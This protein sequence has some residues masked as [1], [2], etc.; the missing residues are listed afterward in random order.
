VD[1][2][3]IT[4]TTTLKRFN[5]WKIF[6]VGTLILSH[7]NTDIILTFIIVLHLYYTVTLVLLLF[8]QKIHLYR[9][10]ICMLLCK[11]VCY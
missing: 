10:N 1:T 11:N 5:Q 4:S 8:R 9:R 3:P 6:T 2:I 7:T